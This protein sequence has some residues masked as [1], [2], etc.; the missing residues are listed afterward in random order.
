MVATES[1]VMPLSAPA[2]EVGGV[3]DHAVADDE[4]VLARAL[5]HPAAVGGEEDRLVVAGLECLHLGQGRVDVHAGALRRRR[6]R[7]GIV[8]PPRAWILHDTPLA[9][10][11]SPR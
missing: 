5:A 7:V 6:H 1:W 8:A 4:D 2:S 9:M 3:D 11:S 10:P